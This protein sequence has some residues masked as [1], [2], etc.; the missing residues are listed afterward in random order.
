MN[1][2]DE[3]GYAMVVALIALLTVSFLGMA[4]MEYNYQENQYLIEDGKRMSAYYLARA[5]AIAT[6]QGWKDASLDSKPEGNVL[7]D[8]PYGVG[9]SAGTFTTSLVNTSTNGIPTQATIA[10]KGTVGD[11]TQSLTVAITRS[12]KKGHDID[13]MWYDS[14]DGRVIDSGSHPYYGGPVQIAPQKKLDCNLST[15]YKAQALYFSCPVKIESSQTLGLNAET[16]VFTDTLDIQPNAT[17][18]LTLP[19]GI[20]ISY[21]NNL[22]GRVFFKDVYTNGTYNYDFS[23]KAYYFRSDVPIATGRSDLTMISTEDEVKLIPPTLEQLM[24]QAVWK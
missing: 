15:T 24:V 10:S 13:L 20:G 6:L 5:G 18:N 14:T 4:L 2:T 17:V 9:N 3:K 22:W 11:Q 19:D 21:N 7:Q 12:I 23:N 16:I 8:V 1:R